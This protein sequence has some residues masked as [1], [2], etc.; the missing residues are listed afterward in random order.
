[1]TDQTF[2]LP[3]DPKASYLAHRD[4]IDAAVRRVMEG[5]WYIL[6]PEVSAFE[7]AFAGYVGTT[8]AVGAGSGTDALHLA[9]RAAGIGAG[10]TVATVSHTAVATVAA[11][12]LAGARPLLVD[13]DPATF[14]VDPQHLA[15]AL[16]RPEGRRVRAV[17]VVHLYGHPAD[18]P[19]I[20]DIARRHDLMVIEDCAQSHGATLLGRRT[21]TWGH[22]A[23][24]SFYPTKNLGALGDGGAIV[25]NDPALAERA[26]A[27]REYGWRDRYVSDLAGM[28]TRLD[29]L[30]AAVLRA[31][32]PHLD[33]EN[34]RRRAVA[35]AYDAALAGSNV[36]APPCRGDVEHVYHQYVVRAPERDALQAFLKQRGIG[37]AVHYPQPVHLQ[38][39]YRDRALAAPG[40]LPHTERA[41]REILS[42][43]M[44]PHLS[45]DAA[46]RVCD[47]LQAWRPEPAVV[48]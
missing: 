24:F 46:A 41:C 2:I 22:A 16:R 37:T 8:H 36:H 12:E 20:L 13:I 18:M 6:G 21:G 25:T 1:M 10:D 7:H 34:A 30:Q 29:E 40:G 31:K 47:A 23:A 45:A 43:P 48:D 14:T 19:A 27:L 42:L 39:A 4:A 32:L 38:P 33:A 26:R 9:L 28:N 15:D 11:I 44:H 3:A 5:G 17:I 35:T